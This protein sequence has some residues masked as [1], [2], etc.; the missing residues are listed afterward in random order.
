[1]SESFWSMGG[2]AVYVWSS[3]GLTGLVLLFGFFLCLCV[4]FFHI[5]MLAFFRS[6]SLFV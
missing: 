3:F 4:C 5:P 6:V 2:Y 1:M